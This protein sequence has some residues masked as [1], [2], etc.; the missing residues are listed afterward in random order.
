MI[1]ILRNS[2][3]SEISI[4]FRI[5]R[6]QIYSQRLYHDIPSRPI[7][8]TLDYESWLTLGYV[9]H[10]SV[11]NKR[12]IDD[13]KEAVGTQKTVNVAPCGKNVNRDWLWDGAASCTRPQVTR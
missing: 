5:L 7:I 4:Y 3:K 6:I 13:V 1:V 11:K 10:D 8:R 9:D 2:L 12:K